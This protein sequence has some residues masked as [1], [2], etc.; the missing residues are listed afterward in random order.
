MD[1][2]FSYIEEH[3]KGMGSI[4]IFENG[5]EVYQRTYGFANI[6][7]GKKANSTTKYRIG[8]ITKTF[9]AT[10]IMKLVEQGKLSLDTKLDKF[11]PEIKNSEKI[12]I[13]NLLRHTSGIFSIT[14]DKNYF[15]WMEKPISKEA[16]ISKIKGYE[17]VFEPNE[18]NE[19]SNSN[20]VLL[21]FIA[22][23]LYG[24][25]YTDIIQ[26]IIVKPLGLKN[27]YV[28]GKIDVKQNEA[29]SY[30]KLPNWE[31]A[32][33]TDM[34]VPV[35]AGAIVSTPTDLNT[36]L[37]GLFKNKIIKPHTFE[38][39][40]EI[41]EGT[42]LGIFQ[43]PFYDKKAFGHSGSIDGFLASSYYFT[44]ENVSISYITNGVE[45]QMNEILLGA[46]SIFYGMDYEV[47]TYIAPI[48]LTE[49]QL[50]KYKGLYSNPEFPLK[51]ELSI[52]DN[53]LILQAT[54]QGAV[55]LEATDVNKFRFEPAML[56]IEFATEGGKFILSQGGAD[57]EF[58]R[59]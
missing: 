5:K 33:E 9:T 48:E 1:S 42:G 43:I 21:T 25:K 46:L 38:K 56:T 53:Q 13:E 55:P 41:K 59:E 3:D 15:D 39:M 12:T 19:Y 47:P 26:D 24:K 17:P 7:D 27:T 57:L 36:F 32:T 37:I 40:I 8:S 30:Q 44:G 14:S 22:E 50:N 45:M 2:L 4:S 28:G 34:S 16:L 31:L 52:K 23:K 49:E 54:G 51:I 29:L 35:G 10:T 6:A 18:R 11:Y 20:Y 58:V